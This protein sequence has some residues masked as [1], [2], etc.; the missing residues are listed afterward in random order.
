MRT[1]LFDYIETFYNRTL[2]QRGLADRT[3]AEVYAA[4]RAA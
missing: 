3:P 2:H 4:A 1:I